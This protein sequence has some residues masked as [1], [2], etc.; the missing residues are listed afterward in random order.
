[1]S[2]EALSLASSAAEP[3]PHLPEQTLARFPELGGLTGSST[4][5]DLPAVE[6][7]IDEGTP[8]AEVAA[9]FEAR[10]ELPGII[11]TSGGRTAGA[12]S[13]ARFFRHISR[14]YGFQLYMQRPIAVL[15]KAEESPCLT[16][17]AEFPIHE[18]T[19]YALTRPV[20]QVYEPVVVEYPD[21]SAR[22]LD[23][24]VLL[25]AQSELLT[26]SHE[27]A[28]EQKELAEVANRAKSDFLATMS[29]E[30]RTPMNGILGMAE[31][32]LDTPL[33]RE[34]REYA[35]HLKESADRLLELLNDILDFSKIEAGRLDL[36]QT[37]FRLRDAIGFALNTLAVRAE[38]KGL[39]LAYHVAPEV[40]EALVGDPHRLRQ[41]IVNLVG[42]AL[43]FT[44][45]GEVVVT[46][47]SES[48]APESATL[49]VKVTD[50][51]IGIPPEKRAAIFEAFSQAD[52]S[53]ARRY[54][55]TGLGLA[56]CTQLVEL[57]GGRIWVESEQG[58][59]SQFQFTARFEVSDAPAPEPA[60]DLAGLRGM[61]ILVADAH[62]TS[63]RFL[64]EVL[65]SWGVRPLEAHDGPAALDLLRSARA[66]S[67]PIHLALVSSRLPGTDSLEV[68]GAVREE[69]DLRDT[70]LVVLSPAG[71]PAEAA[72]ARELGAAACLTTPVRPSELL[73]T[74]LT[75]LLG[76]N[77]G[78]ARHQPV[79]T[80]P[81]APRQALRILLAEDNRVNQVLAVTLLEKWG[82]RVTVAENGRV[83]LERLE[84]EPFDLVLMDVQ[85]PEMSGFE[86]TT[87]IRERERGTDAHV[88]IIAMT[89][90]AIKGDR[91][92][93]LDAGM[94][95]YV[96]KPIQP[97]AVQ[98]A[99]AALAPRGSVESPEAP[100]PRPFAAALGR[101]PILDSRA[102]EA[103]FEGQE[104]LLAD[105]KE[106]LFEDWGRHLEV[107]RAA[108]RDGDAQRVEAVAHTVKGAVANFGALAARRAAQQLEDAGRSEELDDGPQ[109]L[110]ALEAEMERFREAL[111]IHGGSAK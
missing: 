33:A 73:D 108:I 72:R 12:I 16:F 9:L 38:Q 44:E 1:M 7:L 107:L 60:A 8:G 98:E 50:T 4:L 11:V 36:E 31:L 51:G 105:L 89:A 17:P 30:L 101:E 42:N 63:R 52:G 20:D 3:A 77:A 75:V 14:H 109:L 61:Q 106:V 74:L 67:A 83:A 80:R 39:E 59:G 64:R 41:V 37:P 53:T 95:G 79:L 21:G 56:I 87:R 10:P 28:R 40:P 26:L 88:P 93:C 34:Q 24:Y 45:R 22:L 104:A 65:E 92:R 25:L 91:E 99:I 96:T 100:A 76:A 78:E 81:E 97:G 23:S 110:M 94:D 70:P 84:R 90:H 15:L 18:A 62:P 69:P 5:E 86:A 103:M 58:R 46:V 82:H 29:H 66:N 13:R 71:R 47:A 102:L 2:P 27:T 111:A 68:V 6:C 35:G 57:M 43:K 32:L 48:L 54:G 55:G 85:M 49:H 19:R